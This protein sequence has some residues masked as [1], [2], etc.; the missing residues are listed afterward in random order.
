MTVTVNILLLH[1]NENTRQLLSDAR[2]QASWKARTAEAS[3]AFRRNQL[4]RQRSRV[5]HRPMASTD[6]KPSTA[7]QRCAA[8]AAHVQHTR[9]NRGRGASDQ[10]RQSSSGLSMQRNRPTHRPQ[11]GREAML[12][13]SRELKHARAGANIAAAEN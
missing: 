1:D 11:E 8:Q 3:S 10:I 9:L 4:L 7:W 5:T 6:A 13:K 12:R 2:H